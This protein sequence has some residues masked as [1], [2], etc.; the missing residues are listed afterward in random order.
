M[1]PSFSAHSVVKTELWIRSI[2]VMDTLN[3]IDGAGQCATPPSLCS[4]HGALYSR[5]P[6][7]HDYRWEGQTRSHSSP[8]PSQAASLNTP[9]P[10]HSVE[11]VDLL[12][13]GMYVCRTAVNSRHLISYGYQVLHPNT[14]VQ[15]AYSF[16]CCKAMRIGRII[17]WS[18]NLSPPFCTRVGEAWTSSGG[19]ILRGDNSGAGR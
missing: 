6:Y 16:I 1:I 19:K 17:R 14:E 7:T 13:S 10:K 9:Q 3:L 8:L 11:P 4:R 15:I 5:M 12:P 2:G 18:G